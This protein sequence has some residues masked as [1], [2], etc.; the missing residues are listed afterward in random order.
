MH[1]IKRSPAKSHR[2]AAQK[3]AIRSYQVLKTSGGAAEKSGALGE[4]IGCIWSSVR[5]GEKGSVTAS[6]SAAGAG[7]TAC[8]AVAG[9]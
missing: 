7:C 4:C 2:G 9:G 3:V 1:E 6:N 8:V 5:A